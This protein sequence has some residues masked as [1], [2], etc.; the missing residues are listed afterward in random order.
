[1]LFSQISFSQDSTT[2]QNI[3]EK[4]IVQKLP[5]VLE[6]KQLKSKIV[7]PNFKM[8]L[9]SGQPGGNLNIRLCCCSNGRPPLFII[10]GK[11]MIDSILTKLKPDDIE[12]LIALSGLKATE[13]YGEKAKDGVIIITTKK[14]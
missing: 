3:D 8:P 1:M 11:E 7:N 5:A 13:K 9:A 12:S 10:D 6:Q 14:K 2:I 4:W